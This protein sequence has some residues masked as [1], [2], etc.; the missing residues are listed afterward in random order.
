MIPRIVHRR[1]RFGGALLVFAFSLC[2]TIHVCAEIV[3]IPA[4]HLGD[5]KTL[6]AQLFLP[7]GK[8]DTPRPAAILLH[9]CGGIGAKGELN[10][11]HAMW[12]DWL[13]ERGFIVLLPESFSSRGVEEI[14]TQKNDERTIKQRD[15]V[16]DVL[17]ARSWLELRNDVDPEKLVLWG[18]SNGGGTVLAMIV[19][20]DRTNSPAN[21][22][23]GPRIQTFAQA[24]SFYPGCS[25]YN[26][27][28]RK[29]MLSA[30]LALF[31]G[32]ADDWTPAAP[33][34]AW[35]KRLREQKQPVTLKL[36]K[37][38]FHDFDAPNIK[39]RVRKEVPNGVNPGKGV[40]VA[41]DPLARE[42]AKKEIELLLRT[43]KLI[44]PNK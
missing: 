17:A 12:K 30:P 13:V 44:Q 7:Q 24:I 27:S 37:G 4:P 20:D 23:G 6:R 19:R 28:T 32:E 9:G 1:H 16:N 15:R 11:R 18:W 42:L 26:T 31:I 34:E 43:K 8:S 29:Q 40:T 41:P 21:L 35:V 3:Q 36:Y 38:A 22:D 2:A 10:P 5:G 14:C 25:T 39:H 33:C